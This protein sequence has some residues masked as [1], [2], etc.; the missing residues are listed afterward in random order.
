[1]KGYVEIEEMRGVGHSGSF[2]VFARDAVSGFLQ[3]FWEEAG[4]MTTRDARM[5]GQGNPLEWR[6][7]WKTLVEHPLVSPHVYRKSGGL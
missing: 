3:C 7:M 4:L 1:M 6:A 2:V 5:R